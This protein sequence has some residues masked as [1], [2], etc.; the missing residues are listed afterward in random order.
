MSNVSGRHLVQ[1]FKAGKSEALSSQRLSRVGYK[2]TVKNPAKFPSVCASVPVIPS[3]DIILSV[4]KMV[5]HIRTML[6]N[7]QDGIFR[8][9]YESSDGKLEA[10]HD[11]ELDIASCIAFLDAEATGDRLTKAR[12]EAWFDAEIS[13]NLLVTIAEKMGVEDIENAAVT[14][15]AKI[16]RDVLS[17]LAGGKTILNEKQIKGCR[18]A[19]NLATSEDD[20]SVKL[21]AR[22]K[23]M[24]SPKSMEELLDLE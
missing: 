3:Q 18:Y 15:H 8:S 9:L 7:A 10:V 20:V 6:E 23:A 16:Y 11:S 2:S 12:I 21:L 19:I 17:M 4:D 24:E 5:D 13:D 1:P 22:L 14:K